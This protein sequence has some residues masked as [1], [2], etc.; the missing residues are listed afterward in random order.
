MGIIAIF[1]PG[2]SVTV[3]RP[4]NIINITAERIMLPSIVFKD[5]TFTAT[6]GQ[7][8][9]TLASAPASPMILV[10]INGVGQNLAAGDYT[11]VG[12]TLT[13]SSGVNAGDTV[14]GVYQ[15]LQT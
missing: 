3:L 8:V 12:T 4:E 5:F 14:F 2:R 9:F 1:R 6:E 13:L 15:E 10:W 11:I 7:T